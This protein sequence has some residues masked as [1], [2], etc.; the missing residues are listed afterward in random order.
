MSGIPFTDE[1]SSARRDEAE[2]GVRRG[3][4]E[5]MAQ[6]LSIHRA[7][8]LQIVRFRIN[9]RVSVRIDAEDVLQEAF[10]DAVKR[11]EHF[12][13]CETMSPFVRL[14]EIVLQTLVA[15]HRRHLGVQARDCYRETNLGQ[16]VKGNES[17]VCLGMI[18]AGNLT[19]PSGEAVRQE[20]VER[21]HVALGTLEQIDCEVL[22]MRHFEDLSNKEVSQALGIKISA[23]SR[24]YIRAVKRLGNVLTGLS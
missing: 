9:P 13:D 24:R 22:M 4:P 11:I 21:M 5:A 19:S 2:M 18:L 14:R 20:M 7:R 10:L 15:V 17:S 3:E 23:A 1:S 16:R 12:R 6:F 8:L